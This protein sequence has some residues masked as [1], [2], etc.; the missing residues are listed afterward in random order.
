MGLS[1]AVSESATGS[2]GDDRRALI[3]TS[4]ELYAVT[5]EREREREHEQPRR[6]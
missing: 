1:G 6:G 5:R 2:S 3:T 4:E